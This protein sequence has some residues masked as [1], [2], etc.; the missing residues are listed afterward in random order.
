MGSGQ[1]EEAR[2]RFLR[3]GGDALGSPPELL[4]IGERFMMQRSRLDLLVLRNSGLRPRDLDPPGVE[5]G[6]DEIQ[7][8]ERVLAV[9]LVPQVP[10]E[11]VE[12]HPEAIADS[13]G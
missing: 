3:R 12:S 11:R 10:G 8:V 1:D 7:L 2:Q 4:E 5:S 13:V 6:F 9:L